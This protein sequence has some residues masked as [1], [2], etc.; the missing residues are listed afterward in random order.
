[1]KEPAQ[2]AQACVI[3]MHGLG[4]D[5]SDMAGLANQLTVNT[6]A[7]RHVF[8]DAPL[9]AVTLN[10]GM[11]MPAWYDIVGM[12]LSDRADEEGIEQ[13]EAII[14]QV[15]DAQ[16]EDG[17]EYSRIFLAG[18]SQGGAM[19]LHTALNVST[20]LAGVIAL[21]AYLPMA[22]QTNAKLDKTTPFFIASGQFDPLVLPLWTKQSKDWITA[23]GYESLS[24]H[25]YPMEHSICLEEIR[26]VSLWLGDKAQELVQ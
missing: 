10:G 26:D 19:A 18:F 9:R 5:A 2:P 8:I 25:Q 3:W 16:V 1:M 23:K 4:A 24:C 13:S 17:F 14:R 21:S 11:V 6:V 20:R 22:T 15:M 7:L 12:D